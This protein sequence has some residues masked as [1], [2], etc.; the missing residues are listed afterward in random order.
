MR[1]DIDR[2]FLGIIGIVMLVMIIPFSLFGGY[3]YSVPHIPE[4][5]SK[6]IGVWDTVGA[7]LTNLILYVL[8]AFKFIKSKSKTIK[9][10]LMS[11]IPIAF[12]NIYLIEYK[13]F[14]IYYKN[15]TY[16]IIFLKEGKEFWTWKRDWERI[17]DKYSIKFVEIPDKYKKYSKDKLVDLVVDKNIRR[18][19]VLNEEDSMLEHIMCSTENGF[20]Y[21]YKISKDSIANNPDECYVKIINMGGNE[22]FELCRKGNLWFMKSTEVD[23]QGNAYSMGENVIYDEKGY[24]NDLKKFVNK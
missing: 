20:K 3:L 15:F 12:L 6:E 14:L 16:K 24:I 19:C 23:K 13:H 22:Y 17:W 2:I 10:Y 18:K 5:V 9:M 11:V 7:G 21:T 8:V 4:H 1:V